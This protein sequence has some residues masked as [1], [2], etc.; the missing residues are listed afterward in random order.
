MPEIWIVTKP[1]KDFTHIEALNL[2]IEAQNNYDF[3]N[4][5]S[6]FPFNQSATDV[7]SL[8]YTKNALS[9]RNDIKND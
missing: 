5:P 2:A 8:C 4:I 3:A 1:F 6:Q 9:C 7:K